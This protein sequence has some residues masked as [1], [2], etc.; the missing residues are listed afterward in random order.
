LAGIT[1]LLSILT[2]SVW[3]SGLKRTIQQSVDYRRPTFFVEINGGLGRKAGRRFTKSMV[4]QNR[5][6]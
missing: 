4:S 6:E 2:H 1:T 5:Q 3:Q